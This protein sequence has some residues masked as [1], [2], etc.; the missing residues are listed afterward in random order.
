[1]GRNATV[2]D[3]GRHFA[4]MAK[5]L[6][7]GFPLLRR[8]A[9]ALAQPRQRIAE[10]VR[11]RVGQPGRREGVA[12]D[13]P[14]RCGASPTL[15]GQAK[16]FEATI[17]SL[18]D[19]RR[20]EERVLRTKAQFVVEQGHVVAE[21]IE[22]LC[23]NGKEGRGEGLA[24]LG[25][26]LAPVLKDCPGLQ[27]D[28]LEA[29]G[30]DG[31]IPRAGEN[32]EGDKRPIPFLDVGVGRHGGE[33]LRDLFEGCDPLLPPRRCDAQVLIGRR[34]IIRIVGVKRRPK[35]RLAGKP[36]EKVAQMLQG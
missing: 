8:A 17:L 18:T 21:N 14:N 20:R 13:L 36:E 28:M 31:A 32:G 6:T 3:K 12:K 25:V 34:K 35:A 11:L 27:I 23:A 7:P 22:R 15:P 19:A 9:E 5:V 24:A 30:G 2:A 33:N 16:R 29:Q 26:H 10:A 4:L 1:M